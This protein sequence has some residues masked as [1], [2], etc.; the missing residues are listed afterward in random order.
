MPT[1]IFYFNIFFKS[2]RF[3]NTVFSC[4]FFPPPDFLVFIEQSPV[5]LLESQSNIFS[6]FHIS[7]TQKQM[8]K[9]GPYKIAFTLFL[10]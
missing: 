5:M 7:F 3:K 2:K 8:N 6:A 10:K 9:C 4:C 1:D